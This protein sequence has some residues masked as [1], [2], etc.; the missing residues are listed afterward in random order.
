MTLKR[1]NVLYTMLCIVGYMYVYVSEEVSRCMPRVPSQ[2]K[3][4]MIQCTAANAQHDSN[5][6][7]ND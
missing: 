1:N 2:D 6:N 4:P 7:I 3:R 5:S